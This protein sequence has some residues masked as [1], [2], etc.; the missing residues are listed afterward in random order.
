MSKYHRH[1]PERSI[2]VSS[3]SAFVRSYDDR[4]DDKFRIGMFIQNT[5]RTQSLTQSGMWDSC[6]ISSLTGS[7]RRHPCSNIRRSF[8]DSLLFGYI[9]QIIHVTF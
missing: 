1:R 2:Y 7:A 8:Q 3:I 6:C 5:V 4:N 9:L